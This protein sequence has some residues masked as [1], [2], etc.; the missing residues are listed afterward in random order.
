[1]WIRSFGRLIFFP[2]SLFVRTF[3]V[4]IGSSV[5]ELNSKSCERLF[6]SQFGVYAF[7][8][9]VVVGIAAAAAADVHVYETTISRF[10]YTHKL[11]TEH[12]QFQPRKTITDELIHT[13]IA[14]LQIDLLLVVVVF[15]LQFVFN[16]VSYG[17]SSIPHHTTHFSVHL[18]HFH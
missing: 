10:T 2:L 3:L 8:F 14:F 11:Y 16:L 13:A 1:M 12:V 9:V 4:H 17:T 7:V 15:C 18:F 5:A 6:Y